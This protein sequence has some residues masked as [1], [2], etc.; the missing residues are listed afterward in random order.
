MNNYLLIA[1]VPLGQAEKIVKTVNEAGATGAAII[2]A[3]GTYKTARESFLGLVIEPEEEIILIKA[4]KEVADD[5]C[6]RLHNEF[7]ES[8]QRSGFVYVLPVIE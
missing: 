5:L 8:H 4:S 7:K 2:H 3:R 1:A 6:A